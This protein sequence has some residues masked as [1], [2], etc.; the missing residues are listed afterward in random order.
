[1]IQPLVRSFAGIDINVVPDYH[2]TLSEDVPV[3][4]EF[5]AEI[6]AWMRSFF[7][8]K[9][10]LLDGEIVRTR[11]PFSGKPFVTMNPRTYEQLKACLQ[12]AN[13]VYRI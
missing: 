8:P 9:N 2:M 3:T 10:I 1:M 7:K 11:S 6:N 5:R 13:H 4:P 12:A